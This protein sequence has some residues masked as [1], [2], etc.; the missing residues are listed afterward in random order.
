MEILQEIDT[1]RIR[2]L[3]DRG[4]FFWLDLAEPKT[5]DLDP[6][7]E[8]VTIHPLAFEDTNEFGQ[9]AKLDHYPRSALL[10]VYGAAPRSDERPRLVE[11]HLH[12]SGDAL[13]TVSR[14][15][16]TALA[17]ARRD[18]AARPSAHQGHAVHRVLDALA[19]SFLNAL[20]RFD[21]AIDG[22]QESVAERPTS[23]HRQQ[24]FT[25]R[26][27][28]AEMRRVLVP[29]RD[30]LAPGG[31]LLEAIPQPDVD[32][33]RDSFRDVHDHLD[34]AA[35]LLGS[36]REQLAGLLDLYLTEVSTR[37]NEVMKRL[38]MTATVFLPLSF[39]VGFFGMNFGWFVDAITP[40]WTFVV[41][42]IGLLVASTIA[43]AVYLRVTGGD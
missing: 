43:V 21:D 14:E 29:Q 40:L 31:S 18:V 38:T 3:R 26:R 34:R 22:L 30:L 16:L 35:G 13:V 15:P 39:L 20:D 8:L 9:R 11:V 25:L 37:L 12:I 24:I 42:G 32:E 7:R 2:A 23:A 27:E 4:E 36:Y 17:D 28:L 6:L 19:D 5:S 41:F 10:V 33:M 1:D